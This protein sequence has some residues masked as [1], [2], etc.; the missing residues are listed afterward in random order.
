MAFTL[1]SGKYPPN[2]DPTKAPLA[3]GDRALPRLNRELKDTNK[4]VRQRAVMALS[5]HIHDPEHIA[6]ALR[7]GIGETLKTCLTDKDS[8]VRWKAVECLC[9]MSAYAIGRDSFLQL[10][11]IYP[12]AN[13]FDDHEDIVRKYAHTCILRISETPPGAA[14]IVEAQ[15]ISPLVEK[16]QTE[17]DEIKELILDTLHFCIRVDIQSALE[18][19]AMPVITM[20]LKHELTVIRAKAARDIMDLSVSLEGKN[21]AV[22]CGTVPLLRHMLTDQS[23]DVRAKAAGA[24]M[25]IAITTKGKYTAIHALSIQPLTDLVDDINS[26]VRLNAIKALTC[27]AEA[28]E[29]RQ[30]LTQHVIKIHNHE[31]DA[32]AAVAKAAKIAVKV[33][34][35]LP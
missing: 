11:T 22:E 8:T 2:V 13:L 18:A 15:L 5:D 27:L 16:L 21:V 1:I 33:I 34:T 3:Y 20:L 26:E 10:E 19:G 7:I 24:I 30:E 23:A 6:T 35:W 29:A 31:K 12:V 25:T 9:T 32:V 28:P 14:S 17:L 4:I